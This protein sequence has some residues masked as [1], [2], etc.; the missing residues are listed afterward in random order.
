MI[1]HLLLT[2]S[3][4]NLHQGRL[5][6]SHSHCVENDEHSKSAFV[7]PPNEL[8]ESWRRFTIGFGL[9]GAEPGCRLLSVI[10]PYTEVNE[11]A[12]LISLCWTESDDVRLQLDMLPVC[13][14]RNRRRCPISGC[15]ATTNF[16]AR[17]LTK[18][19]S[20][21]PSGKAV[22]L[23]CTPFSMIELHGNSRLYPI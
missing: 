1:S 5:F 6:H 15:W 12:Q 2:Y 13:Q 18:M 9:L 7:L 16:N 21:S 14:N 4:S 23:S 8:H 3:G 17:K 19:T 10:L 22:K 20:W 11:D